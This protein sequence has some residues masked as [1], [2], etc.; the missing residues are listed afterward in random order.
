MRISRDGVIP[1]I[2]PGPIARRLGGVYQLVQRSGVPIRILNTG[3]LGSVL[4]STSPMVREVF[5]NIFALYAALFVA[6]ACYM[7]VDL[8]VILPFQQ[9]FSR[10]QGERAERSPLKQDTEQALDRI[11]EVLTH[12]RPEA[13]PDGGCCPECGETIM[14]AEGDS[15]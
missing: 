4:W 14:A 12:V 15:D 5:P 13:S 2:E 1:Q 9:G 8:S 6:V 3:M 11:D 7:V 10:H